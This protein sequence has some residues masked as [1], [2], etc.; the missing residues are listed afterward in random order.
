MGDCRAGAPKRLL[1][2][3][4]VAPN[5]KV[6]PAGEGG[7]PSAVLIVIACCCATVSIANVLCLA[8]GIL[9]EPNTDV[10]GFR[11]KLGH[12]NSPK[13][14]SPVELLKALC[15][16]RTVYADDRDP[17]PEEGWPVEQR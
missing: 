9:P 13:V 5:E 10:E 11:L 1:C 16:G 7:V 4:V 6:D 2:V 17:I 3:G 14:K 12:E 15:L 8:R